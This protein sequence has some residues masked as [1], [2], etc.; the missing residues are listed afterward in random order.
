MRRVRP[1]LPFSIQLPPHCRFKL[2]NHIPDLNRAYRVAADERESGKK[3]DAE[4][5][6]PKLGDWVVRV[7]H[8]DGFLC[9]RVG[10]ELESSQGKYV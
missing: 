7:G 5:L 1:R 8:T 9:R 2:A 6:V 10:V 3:V 4:D